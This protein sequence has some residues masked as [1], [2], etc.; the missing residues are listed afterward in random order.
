MMNRFAFVIAT[1]DRPQELERL[2]NSFMNQAMK[3]YQI[4]IVDGGSLRVEALCQRFPQ[5]NISYIVSRPPDA[6]KQRSL[7]IQIALRESSYIG[8]MD[9][10]TVLEPT[11]LEE[12]KRFWDEAAPDVGG[13]AFNLMNSPDLEFSKLKQHP[14]VEKLGLYSTRIGAVLPSG[15]HTTLRR[16]STLTQ[17]DW[18]PSGGVVWKSEIFS[19][20]RFDNWF[21]GYTYLEDLDFSY[22]AGRKFRLAVVAKAGYF[23]YPGSSGRGGGVEFGRREVINRAYFVKKNND[24]SLPKCYL[25]LLFRLSISFI[26]AFK[27]FRYY[28]WQRVWG[29]CLGFSDL[30]MRRL[31]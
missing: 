6:V 24:L 30:I 11:A 1:M 9:D 14:L 5:L 12:M 2:L 16:V 13:A 28:N 10:D 26:M 21:K 8:L 27:S 3:P 31:F 7:G 18:L 29:N 19:E 17:V 23:H 22:R 25:G 15:F 4:V 20:F